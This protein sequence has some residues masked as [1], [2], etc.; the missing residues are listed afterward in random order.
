ME[1]LK[2]AAI[3][4]GKR[5]SHQQRE[6]SEHTSHEV[7]IPQ[8][9]D[10]KGMGFLCKPIQY[11]STFEVPPTRSVSLFQNLLLYL[12]TSIVNAVN[13]QESCLKIQSI[14][15]IFDSIKIIS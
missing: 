13:F 3:T 1:E 9:N 10:P 6:T 12:E 14:F 7:Q 4:F 8:D 2:F 11:T 5:A 15:L